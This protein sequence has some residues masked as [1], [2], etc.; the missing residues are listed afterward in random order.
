LAYIDLDE[1]IES[2]QHSLND[3]ENRRDQMM[4]KENKSDKQ[5][6]KISELDKQ[7]EHDKKEMLQASEIRQ[8]DGSVL[9]LASG[10]YFANAYEVNYFS[11]GSSEKF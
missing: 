4:A 8:T 9:N 7:I 2:L 5:L 1:Y 3:K 6:K 11:G 10:V